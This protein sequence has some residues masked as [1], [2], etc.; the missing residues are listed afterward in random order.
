MTRLQ[1]QI[2]LTWLDRFNA[3]NCKNFNF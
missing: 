2:G 1:I 3:R